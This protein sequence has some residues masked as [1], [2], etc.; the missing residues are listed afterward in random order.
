MEWRFQ[1]YTAPDIRVP[2]ELVDSSGPRFPTNRQIVEGSLVD[3]DWR[4]YVILEVS[5]NF[6]KTFLD[7][8]P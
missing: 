7:P 1:F 8:V 2:I 4:F 3:S 5:Q 6:L